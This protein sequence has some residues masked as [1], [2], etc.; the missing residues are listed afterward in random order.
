MTRRAIAPPAGCETTPLLLKDPAQVG[1]PLALR[2]GDYAEQIRVRGLVQGVGLR[3]TVWRL[4]SEYGLRGWVGNDGAGVTALLCGARA[5]I[6]SAIDALRRAPPPLAR[7]DAIERVPAAVPP[8]CSGFRIIESQ[9]DAVHTGVVPDAATCPD[10][11]ARCSTRGRVA[12]AIRSPTAPI[13]GRVCRSSR[14]SPTTA[15]ATT[16][17]AF[18][19]CAA[20]AAEY[21]DPA[22][23]RFHAQPI[24]C[25]ACGPRVWLEPAQPGA[26]CGRCG[27]SAAAGGRHRRGQGAGRLPPRL[28]RHRRSAVAR[29]RQAKRREANRSR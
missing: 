28:R 1:D 2:E 8:N 12:T 3:P 11:R 21:R 29:L 22:D 5:D 16:M 19:M 26:G 23:R 6:A 14:R 25:A 17:R 15:A 20:C 13:A 18:G 4:A 27:A 10:C 7:I 9:A 24:A